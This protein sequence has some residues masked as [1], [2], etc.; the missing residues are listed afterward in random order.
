MEGDI[1]MSERER[2]RKSVLDEVKRGQCSLRE[3][4]EV[5]GVSYRQCKRVYARY[6]LEGDAGLVHRRR[7][8]PCARAKSDAMRDKVL[9]RYTERYTG[10]GPT[11]AAEKLAEDGYVLDH[12]TL[13]RWLIAAGLWERAR[14]RGPHRTRRPR[15]EHFG[16]LV[17][18]DG[19]HHAWF[20]LEH[21][22]AC[23]MNLV[24]DATGR[25]LATMDAQETTE[26]AM[27]TLWKWIECYGIPKALYCDRKTVYVTEREPTIEEQL[28]GQ[29]P[30][31]NF[32]K[33]CKKLDIRIITAH[34][35]QAKGRVE[36]NHGVY[37]DRLVHELR[38]REITTM[39]GAN[40]LLQNGF[41]DQLNAK[42]ARPPINTRDLHRRLAKNVDLRDVF[43]FEEYRA[44]GNDWTVRYK[45]H[46]FQIHKANKHLP[47]PKQKVLVRTWLDG[48]I[49]LV[50]NNYKLNH[51]LLAEPPVKPTKHDA[52]AQNAKQSPPKQKP[53]QDHPWRK[54]RVA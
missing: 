17:Q 4:S 1:L 6:R 22:S 36:R 43:C 45:N 51:E 27:R 7:G 30:L 28:A 24:D 8:R 52:T 3:A 25:T 13:R 11:L 14:K 31:T 10:I 18:F 34:S 47:K 42:F 48:T 19:S 37:Q 21:P 54:R 35:P 40:T 49:H 5:L 44:V 23:L 38:L 12:E 16:E 9:M 41:V 29:E 15:K 2:T 53:S 46:Y 20:G 33:S 26:A 50:Y 39:D 32:G